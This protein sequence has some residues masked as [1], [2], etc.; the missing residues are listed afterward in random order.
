MRPS[1]RAE[2]RCEVRSKATELVSL[3]LLSQTTTSLMIR[4]NVCPLVTAPEVRN[5]G[6]SGC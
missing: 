4:A 1:G 3:F 6:V 5:P 2:S